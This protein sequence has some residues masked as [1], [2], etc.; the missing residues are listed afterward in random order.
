MLRIMERVKA[1]LEVQTLKLSTG[2][3]RTDIIQCVLIY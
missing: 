3:N 2:D 1:T